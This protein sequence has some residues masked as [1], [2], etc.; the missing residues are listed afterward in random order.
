LEQAALH[1][2]CS[3]ARIKKG[4]KGGTI[5][6]L[7]LEIGGL[8]AGKREITTKRRGK[9]KIQQTSPTSS[10]PRGARI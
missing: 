3:E 10:F 1:M 8:G 9:E 6:R 5:A 7:R 2:K 4:Q